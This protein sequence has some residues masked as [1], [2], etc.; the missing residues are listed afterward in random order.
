VDR[1]G[2]GQAGKVSGARGR[3][4]ALQPRS[5]PSGAFQRGLGDGRAFANEHLGAEHRAPAKEVPDARDRVPI[6]SIVPK[7]RDLL[8]NAWDGRDVHGWDQLRV[9]GA[10]ARRSARIPPTTPSPRL[11]RALGGPLLNLLGGP[12]DLL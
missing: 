4:N 6:S 11:K 10:N 9:P 12:L 1:P 3:A 5:P 8:P 2:S 7:E